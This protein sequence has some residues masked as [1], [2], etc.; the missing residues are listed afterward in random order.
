MSTILRKVQ[1]TKLELI[2]LKRSIAVSKRIHKILE[3][4]KEVLLRKLT[5]TVEEA[6]RIRE[7]VMSE[8][9]SVYRPLLLAYLS[10][11]SAR[12]DAIA[13]STPTTVSVDVKLHKMMDVKVPSLIIRGEPT[14]ARYG[15]SDTSPHLDEAVKSIASLLPRILKAAELENA[16]FRIAAELERTQR[17]INA[18]EYI[19]IPGYEEAIRFIS[20]VLEEREREEFVRLK[21]LKAVLERRV[22]SRE[23]L[24]GVGVE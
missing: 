10:L 14:M 11:G 2:R 16:I 18:L 9:S 20:M 6:K 13:A 7:S 12:I 1:P 17:L 23:A 3:D 24:V 8:I 5:E 15:V 21:K 22:K 4:K 19:I